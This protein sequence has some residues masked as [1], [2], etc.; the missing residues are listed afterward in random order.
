MKL[1]SALVGLAVTVG[2]AGAQHHK[3]DDQ[4][5]TPP[6]ERHVHHPTSQPPYAGLLGRGIK[7]LSHEQ[8]ADLR[9]GRA[10]SLALP[11]ELNGY[12][13]PKHVLDLADKLAMTDQQ[14]QET[15][16]LVDEMQSQAVELGAGL[17][18]AEAELDR[19][20]RDK[21]ATASL[22]DEAAAKVGVAQGRL[23]ASH[24]KH[25]L[26]TTRLLSPEQV[27]KY[28]LARGYSRP[29]ASNETLNISPV[30]K[31]PRIRPPLNHDRLWRASVAAA[32]ATAAW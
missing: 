3:P 1:L 2:S 7:A 31:T 10:M 4:P 23:R 12:P 24:L 14:R 11:A 27:A 26:T 19:L 32:A 21:R 13:G 20:F 16:R 29:A 18:E 25:H 9:A 30:P 8:V 15:Q 17:I 22:V 28:N 6:P 5:Q